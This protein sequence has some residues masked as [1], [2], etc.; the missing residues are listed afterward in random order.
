MLSLV[1]RWY[2]LIFFGNSQ[3]FVDFFVIPGC[4]DLEVFFSVVEGDSVDMVDF[5]VFR[6]VHY[7]T[8]HVDVFFES[9]SGVYF[10]SVPTSTSL[11]CSPVFSVEPDP[12]FWVDQGVFFFG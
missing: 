5:E 4:A 12:V 6:A 2:T 10:Q 9:F 7:Q 11:F 1:S 8:V 3:N